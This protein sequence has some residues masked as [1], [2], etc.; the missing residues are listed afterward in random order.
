[1]IWNT[2]LVF[3]FWHNDFLICTHLFVSIPHLFICG[4][5]SICIIDA[6]YFSN[7][8][9]TASYIPIPVNRIKKEAFA[10]LLL[11]PTNKN[12]N[13][14]EDRRKI[15]HMSSMIPFPFHSLHHNINVCISIFLV[16]LLNIFLNH[17]LCYTIAKKS[18]YPEFSLNF[19]LSI[20]YWI[21]FKTFVR[22]VSLLVPLVSW[23]FL[24]RTFLIPKEK[25]K[26]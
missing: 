6:I 24:P 25:R 18:Q 23:F 20:V 8:L 26:N 2:L 7:T 1:M 10:L 13:E 3:S 19:S 5:T 17:K 16:S 21:Y 12:R 11:R 9:T 22:Y 14:N 15:Q 4:L